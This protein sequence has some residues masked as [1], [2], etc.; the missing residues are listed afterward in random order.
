M[1][2]LKIEG[3][4]PNIRP[5]NVNDVISGYLSKKKRII[6][7]KIIIPV[8]PPKVN[9]ARNIKFFFQ[10]LKKFNILFK[11]FSYIPKITHNTPLLIPGI[12]A[13]APIKIPFM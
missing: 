12:M 3:I 1:Q 9:G 6:L 10:S 13:P 5:I 11:S 4:Q 8:R 2:I 7:L